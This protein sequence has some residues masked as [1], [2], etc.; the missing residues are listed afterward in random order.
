MAI[1]KLGNTTLNIDDVS[2]WKIDN[3]GDTYLYVTMKNGTQHSVKHWPYGFDPVNV[4][5][6]SQTLES[7]LK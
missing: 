1:V 3:Y 6:I 4:Y 5:D 7:Y 2:S